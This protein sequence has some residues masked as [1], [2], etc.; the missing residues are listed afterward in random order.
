MS[1]PVAPKDYRVEG[2]I[3]NAEA[4]RREKAET[5]EA[6][7]KPELSKPARNYVDLH[8]HAALRADMLGQS[9]LALRLIVA[10]MIAESPLWQVEADP[11]RAAK[12]EIAES[13]AA[14]NGQQVFER[15]RAAIAEMWGLEAESILSHRAHYEPRPCIGDIF[16]RL[17]SLTDEDILRV[18]TFLMAE[19]LSANSPLIDTLGQELGTDMRQHWQPDRTFFVL[20]R[21]EQVLNAMVGE[22]AGTHAAAEHLT[23]TAKTQ[24]SIL[25]ACV[26]GIHTTA[27][28]DWLTDPD[29]GHRGSG[30]GVWG[31]Q[32]V[33]FAPACKGPSCVDALLPLKPPALRYRSTVP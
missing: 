7:P 33:V 14:N 1:A 16:A 22:Y 24:R 25:T 5:D 18:L 6:V 32:C 26:D 15:E 29:L 11:Q 23:A 2:F 9:G 28:A 4:K 8:R 20:I 31:D 19:S 3:T 13:L 12:P 10:H 21:G 17:Q 27:D 30:C